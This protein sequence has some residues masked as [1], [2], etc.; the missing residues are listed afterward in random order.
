MG[1]GMPTPWS[2]TPVRRTFARW[3]LPSPLRPFSMSLIKQDQGRSRLPF[4]VPRL[5][6]LLKI[7]PW[8]R[9]NPRYSEYAWRPCLTTSSSLLLLILLISPKLR[10]SMSCRYTPTQMASRFPVLSRSISRRS[11]GLFSH[12]LRN[13]TSPSMLS[14]NLRATWTQASHNSSR[15]RTRIGLMP[16]PCRANYN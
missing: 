10:S 12:L 9:S 14:R 2:H 16:C 11:W 7:M 6:P 15:K 5:R 3:I 8:P 4:L 1:R 13:A